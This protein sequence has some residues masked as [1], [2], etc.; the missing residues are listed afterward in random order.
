VSLDFLEFLLTSLPEAL[1]DKIEGFLR[2]IVKLKAANRG[3]EQIMGKTQDLLTLAQ[4][5]LSADVL[6]PNLVAVITS[7]M[8]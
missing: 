8:L 5:M 7:D 2:W 4:E 6:L 1:V 3:G